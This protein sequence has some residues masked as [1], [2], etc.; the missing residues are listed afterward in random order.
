MIWENQTIHGLKD[1][2][3]Q[4]GP[5]DDTPPVIDTPIQEPELPDD[6]ETVTISVNVTDVDTGI[7]P[8][9][10]ILSYR[11]NGGN[12][13]NVTM[14]KITGSTYESTIPGFPA[15]TYIE[16]LIAAYD[17]A[18]NEAVEDKL[19]AYYVYTVIPEFS[20]WPVLMIILALTG[21]TVLVAVKRKWKIIDNSFHQLNQKVRSILSF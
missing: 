13:N 5:L 14:S 1:L 17:Y 9:G 2:I 12:W 11:I 16:Y 7:P 18:E 20:T 19:G 3:F 4:I 6:D 15:G 8:E 21:I 10:V